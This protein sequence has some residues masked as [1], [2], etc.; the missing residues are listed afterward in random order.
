MPGQGEQALVL[1]SE[2]GCLCRY[3]PKLKGKSNTHG[4]LVYVQSTLL[5]PNSCMSTYVSILYMF[6]CFDC[7]LSQLCISTVRQYH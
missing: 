7:L 1:K 6:L 2:P 4:D 3:Y 5:H